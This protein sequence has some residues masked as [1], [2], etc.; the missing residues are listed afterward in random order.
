[1]DDNRKLKQ[2]MRETLNINFEKELTKI[3]STYVTIIKVPT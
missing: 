1:M 3:L 2:R